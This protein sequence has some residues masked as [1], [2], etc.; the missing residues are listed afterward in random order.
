MPCVHFL[1]YSTHWR[2]LKRK[3]Y[4]YKLRAGLQDGTNYILLCLLV[5]FVFTFKIGQIIYEHH[6]YFVA[7]SVVFLFVG[8]L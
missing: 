3:L 7:L 2:R 8:H 4:K 1:G 5:L 6:V